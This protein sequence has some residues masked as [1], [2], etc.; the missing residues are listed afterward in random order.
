MNHRPF[1]IL[2]AEKSAIIRHGLADVLKRNS[3]IPISITD[4]SEEKSLKL[5]LKLHTPDILIINP[6]F[7]TQEKI[8]DFVKEYESMKVVAL[9]TTLMDM[10]TLV[11]YADSITIYDEYDTIDNKI[12]N[13]LE[14][15]SEG[16]DSEQLSSRE[17]DIVSCIV[18]GMTN[19]AIAETLCISVHT[20]ITHRKNIAK[21]LQI[22]TPAGLT[23]YAIVNKIVDIKEIKESIN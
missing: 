22:H 17:K 21:K 10:S 16:D 1:K 12:I 15:H 7:P 11:D 20:V 13:L 6:L 2:I 18:R 5:F 4:I 9:I 23:N 3:N 19:K 14:K 8:K